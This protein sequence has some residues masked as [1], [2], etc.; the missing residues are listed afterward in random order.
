MKWGPRTF[1]EHTLTDAA[2]HHRRPNCL[3]SAK[4]TNGNSVPGRLKNACAQFAPWGVGDVSGSPAV[5]SSCQW[6]ASPGGSGSGSRPHP[7]WPCHGRRGCPP[8][9]TAPAVTQHPWSQLY[10]ALRGVLAKPPLFS[11]PL[12]PALGALDSLTF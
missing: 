5:V 1:P 9:Q 8:G 2:Q 11:P 7:H 4:Q 6:N 3:L 12:L 10:R